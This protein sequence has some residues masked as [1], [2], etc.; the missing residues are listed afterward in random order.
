MADNPLFRKAALDKLSSPERLDVL[1]RVTSPM[2]WLALGTIGAILIGVIA[3]SLLGTIPDRIDGRGI[4]LRGGGVLEIKATGTGTITSLNL[5]VN[6]T[7]KT[8]QLIGQITEAQDADQKLEVQRQDLES[9]RREYDSTVSIEQGNVAQ[10]QRTKSTIQSE[11]IDLEGKHAR[12]E[13][14]VARLK[15]LYE[16][17]SITET[18]WTQAIQA[19]ETTNSQIRQRR[20]SLG[21]QDSLIRSASGRI[22]IKLEAVRSAEVRLQEMMKGVKEQTAVS[23]QVAGRVIEVRKGIGD[24]VEAGETIAAVEP[25]ASEIQVIAFVAADVAK[26]IKSPMPTEISPTNVKREEY[27]FMLGNVRVVGEL[28]AS[29]QY[30]QNTLRNEAMVKEMTGAGGSVT[31]VRAVLREAKDTPSGYEWSTSTGPPFKIDSG[32]IV[33][34][35]VIVDRKRPI[36]LVMPFLKKTFGAA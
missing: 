29:P 34:V 15:P 24:R 9:R 33:N 30:V 25:V 2:G 12:D 16:S 17:K 8:A 19:V 23:S 28:A 36:T 6:D 1:M 5:K 26:R 11:I 14:E 22:A 32:T 21:D 3:W 4:L 13:A 18:R 31:E 7:V 35:N 10:A 20:N 27:G